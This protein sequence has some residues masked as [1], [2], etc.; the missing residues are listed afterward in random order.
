MNLESLYLSR[1]WLLHLLWFGLLWL[2]ADS[3]QRPLW[4]IVDSSLSFLTLL[5]LHLFLQ[6]RLAWI[7]VDSRSASLTL[8]LL[9]ELVLLNWRFRL[10][11]VLLFDK[12]ISAFID[13]EHLEGFGVVIGEHGAVVL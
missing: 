12:L 2:G 11:G 7:I 10:L 1:W 4:F 13:V 9:E 8:A 5:P 6:D 3:S